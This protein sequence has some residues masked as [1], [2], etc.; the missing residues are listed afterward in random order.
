MHV[1]QDKDQKYHVWGIV[2][3]W[4]G[5]KSEIA[6]F[7][8]IGKNN[9]HIKHSVSYKRLN[10]KKTRYSKTRNKPKVGFNSKTPRWKPNKSNLIP[11][12]G[13]Y[14]FIFNKISNIR[15]TKIISREKDNKDHSIQGTDVNSKVDLECYKIKRPLTKQNVNISNIWYCLFQYF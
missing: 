6:A 12:T 14:S 10:S 13:A 5:L 9:Y 3:E 8:I 7:R 4:N 2:W 11:D 1:F 15:S